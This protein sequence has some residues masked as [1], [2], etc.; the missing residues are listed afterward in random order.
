MGTENITRVGTNKR[1]ALKTK[2][3]SLYR[4]RLRTIYITKK[5]KLVAYQHYSQ[6][7]KHLICRELCP[8]GVT[9][10][11]AVETSVNV[12]KHS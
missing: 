11:M 6:R 2:H 9:A 10:C 12:W 3:C 5:K 7:H 1:S 4:P 8:F